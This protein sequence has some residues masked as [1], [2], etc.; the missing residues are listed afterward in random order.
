MVMVL[1][2]VICRY[3]VV[4]K[5]ANGPCA[6]HASSGDRFVHFVPLHLLARGD[7]PT[8][9]TPLCRADC[10]APKVNW[11]TAADSKAPKGWKVSGFSGNVG[12]SRLCANGWNGYRGGNGQATLYATLKGS[13]TL[14]AKFRDCWKEGSAS[15]YLNNK[16]KA[17]SKNK[18]G[19]W[20]TST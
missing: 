18:S 14:T 20:K 13:G 2:L 9:P 19:A 11:K 15:I 4:P 10:G 6:R 3:M 5:L 8:V 7:P 12:N 16:L 1:G 17:S